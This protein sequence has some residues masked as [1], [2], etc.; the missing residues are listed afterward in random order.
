MDYMLH[1]F[2]LEGKNNMISINSMLKTGALV[3]NLCIKDL[4][5][6]KPYIL[7]SIW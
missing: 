1:N 7:S 5:T 3:I 6:G 2:N 4:G